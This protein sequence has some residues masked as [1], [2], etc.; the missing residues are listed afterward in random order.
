M[1]ENYKNLSMLLAHDERRVRASVRLDLFV[2]CFGSVTI[3]F[4][5][6]EVLGNSVAYSKHARRVKTTKHVAVF[7]RSTSVLERFGSVSC[8]ISAPVHEYLEKLEAREWMSVVTRLI[9]V[10]QR[11]LYVRGPTAHAL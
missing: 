4:G 8:H 3:L 9:Q 2:K 5:Q 1:K 11:V 7:T 10:L 6:L